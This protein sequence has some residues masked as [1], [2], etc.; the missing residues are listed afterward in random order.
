M[1]WVLWMVIPVVVGACA[2]ADERRLNTI[3]SH[4]CL[5]V[6]RRTKFLIKLSISMFLGV[7]LGGIVP[8]ALEVLR[9]AIGNPGLPLNFALVKPNAE[10]NILMLCVPSVLLTIVC[11]YASSMTKNILQAIG[12][13]IIVVTAS[14]LLN[15]VSSVFLY[16]GVFGVSSLLFPLLALGLMM[17]AYKNAAVL[18]VDWK[19]WRFNLAAL[20]LTAWGVLLLGFIT[21]P[22]MQ[23]RLWEL[24]MTL[25]PKHGPA[26]LRGNVRPRIVSIENG[27]AALVPDGRVWLANQCA[28]EVRYRVYGIDKSGRVVRKEN[29]YLAGSVPVSGAFL[30]GSNWVKIAKK[31]YSN[32]LLALQE[33]G[34]I[35]EI[36]NN[37]N[38]PRTAYT[39]LKTNALGHDPHAILTN[40]WVIQQVWSNAVWKDIATG[41]TFCAMIKKDGTLWG[42]GQND[43]GAL[44]FGAESNT[45]QEPYQIGTNSDWIS[46]FGNAGSSITAIKNDG[47]IWLWDRLLSHQ[48]SRPKTGNYPEF[49]TYKVPPEVVWI[50]TFRA[51]LFL[52]QNG[53]LWR[54][55]MNTDAT[56]VEP[57]KQLGTWRQI[58]TSRY[59]LGNNG[60]LTI[61][62]YERGDWMDRIDRYISSNSDWIAVNAERDF[63]GNE[64]ALAL[65]ADGTISAWEYPLYKNP[66]LSVRKPVWNC[67][68]FQITPK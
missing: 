38:W 56:L 30:S 8:T 25:E 39:I 2:I 41:E 10:V 58:P 59:N 37:V 23:N 32:K 63:E 24:A 35:Y 21:G 14:I 50:D 11:F 28:T 15:A 29:P 64:H 60:E 27:V 19:L 42:T 68:L 6:A 4:N 40:K 9:Y 7:F 67:N 62:F 53:T 49:K 48:S 18:R 34:S 36:A 65:A 54:P 33:D 43:M 13:S 55:D 26:V 52:D 61:M 66:S 22:F 1:I 51:Y 47:S 44:C 45:N 31:T 16:N 57:Q 20:I 3:E 17:L 5:P 12:V 46:V